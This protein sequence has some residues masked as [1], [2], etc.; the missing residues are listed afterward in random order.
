MNDFTILH[1][2]DLHINQ[3]GERLSIL[4]ENLL[5]DIKQ[6]MELV[7]NII[8]VVTGDI[9]HKGNYDY[10]ENAIAFFKKLKKVLKEKVKDIYIVPG[11]HD[12]VRN[13]IDAKIIQEYKFEGDVA[14][15]FYKDYW[16]YIMVSFADYQDMVKK[17]YEIFVDKAKVKKKVKA[18]TYGTFVTEI[19]DKRICFMAFNTAWSCLGD[20]DERNLK[21]GKFQ[22]DE[23]KEEYKENI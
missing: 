11:N 5:I 13:S 7:D 8:V 6:E 17:I 16:K 12:K 2:S 15:K 9:V 3:K 18:N 22:L 1:L 14:D 20:I 21:F 4:M 10:K 19:N 23:I